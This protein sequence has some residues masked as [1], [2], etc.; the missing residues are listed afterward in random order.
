MVWR[1]LILAACAA[2][3]LGAASAQPIN[4]GN[5]EGQLH[6]ARAAVAPGETFTIILRQNIREG[7]HTY[8]RNPGDSGE[9]TALP[10]HSSSAA[11][12]EAAS[13]G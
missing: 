3:M 5:V 1:G 4:T 10:K 12:Q 2:L 13:P 8:W 6:A 11:R 7:W 9:P